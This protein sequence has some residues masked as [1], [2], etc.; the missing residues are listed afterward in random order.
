MET[1]NFKLPRV[2]FKS[3]KAAQI[4]AYFAAQSSGRSVEKLKLIKLIYL[5]EREHLARH[6][7]PMIYDELFGMKDGPICSSALN[8]INDSPT[9]TIW[10][11]F[12]SKQGNDVSPK[13]NFSR[14]HL[15]ELSDAEISVLLKIW[16]SFGH[17]TA[18]QIRNYAHRNCPEYVEVDKGRR[19]ISYKT[20]LS[21]VGRD[22]AEDASDSIESYR[23]VQALL[24]M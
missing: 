2:G 5:A 24:T 8:G 20:L 7:R 22:D 21:A 18:S 13:M 17:M 9:D 14:D 4:A 23:R 3:R 16:N 1:A 11:S 10:G 12:I 15:D 6:G 19:P